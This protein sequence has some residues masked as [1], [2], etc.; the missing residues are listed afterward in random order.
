MWNRDESEGKADQ[1]KGRIKKTVGDL[2]G[3]RRL[4]DEGEVDETAGRVQE[5]VGRGRRKVG[6]AIEDLGDEIKR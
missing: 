4:R 3:D 2:T 5:T 6:E 1:V